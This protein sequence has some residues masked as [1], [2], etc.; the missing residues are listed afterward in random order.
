MRQLGS[1]IIVGT[2]AAAQALEIAAA[3]S[4][5]CLPMSIVFSNDTGDTVSDFVAGLFWVILLGFGVLLT[6]EGNRSAGDGAARCVSLTLCVRGLLRGWHVSG[7]SDAQKSRSC[8]TRVRPARRANSSL[9][10]SC[11]FPRVSFSRSGGE[12]R[13][14]CSSQ[15]GCSSG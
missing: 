1:C 11:P 5:G 10:C 4:E 3:A 12:E 13:W 8:G 7:T 15:A 2:S 9:P 14:R 6:L